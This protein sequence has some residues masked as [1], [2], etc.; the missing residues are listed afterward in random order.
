MGRVVVEVGAKYSTVASA[1]GNRAFHK[2][3]ES[4]FIQISTRCSAGGQ[5]RKSDRCEVARS[6]GADDWCRR[7]RIDRQVAGKRVILGEESQK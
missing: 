5:Q 2:G 1:E 7:R 6:K 4:H 3:A